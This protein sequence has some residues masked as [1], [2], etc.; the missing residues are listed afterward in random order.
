MKYQAVNSQELSVN[1]S[2]AAKSANG[3]LKSENLPNGRL[4]PESKQKLKQKYKQSNEA[5]APLPP[6]ASSTT[7]NPQAGST[8]A[9][10]G[11]IS[12]KIFRLQLIMFY[13]Y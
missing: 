13:M 3:S 2:T 12:K 8:T 1:P 10:N 9:S 6:D 4:N 5:A 11:E 7:D